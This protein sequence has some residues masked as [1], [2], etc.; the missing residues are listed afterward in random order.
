L[1]E[2]QLEQL[3]KMAHHIARNM[4]AEGDAE[5]VARKTAEHIRKFWTPDMQRQLLEL[6]Q[7]QG[8]SLP[9]PVTLAA[10]QLQQG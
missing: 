2:A 6:S 8:D 9:A 5:V 7:E 1:A 10:Q 3:V 4:A